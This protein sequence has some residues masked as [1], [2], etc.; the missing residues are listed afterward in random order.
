MPVQR[1]GIEA[2][3]GVETFEVSLPGDNQR[4]DL[5]H[6]HVGPDKGVIELRL[7]LLRQLC[8]ITLE[9]HRAAAGPPVMRHNA[10]RGDA[11]ESHDLLSLIIFD[12]STLL[13]TFL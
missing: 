4:V 2:D 11:P 5:K 8:G 12:L 3:L 7:Q 1:V 6:R 13:P 9:A 10:S